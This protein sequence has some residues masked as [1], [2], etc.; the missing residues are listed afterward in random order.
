MVA[1]LLVI[2]LSGFIVY[3][4]ILYRIK[5]N[6]LH[7]ERKLQQERFNQELLQSK[8]EVQ[9]ST[10]ASVGVEL[11]DNLGQLL[12]TALMLVN[13]TER[14]LPKVPTTLIDAG[15]TLNKSINELRSLAKALNSSWL[16]QFDLKKNVETELERININD[17]FQINLLFP[18]QPL[19]LDPEHQ[20]L[21]FRM[22]QEAIQNVLRHAKASRVSISFSVNFSNLLVTIED[23]GIGFDMKRKSNG[24]GIANMRQRALSLGGSV[25]WQSGDN[26]TTIYISIPLKI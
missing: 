17:R 24:V 9:E 4:T 2:L 3:L 19:A 22:I 26:G 13:I 5:K 23:N 16:S 10:F 8:V 25:K 11:H 7:A 18:A 21:V 20:F 1:G 12:S 14:N 6:Q 15:A